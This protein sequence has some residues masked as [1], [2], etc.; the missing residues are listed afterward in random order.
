MAITLAQPLYIL[1]NSVCTWQLWPSMDGLSCAKVRRIPLAW[2]L[3]LKVFFY[4]L[5]PDPQLLQ[6]MSRTKESIHRGSS[7][8]GN[9]NFYFQMEQ[10]ASSLN[11]IQV[12]GNFTLYNKKQWVDTGFTFVCMKVA[13]W[14]SL[15]KKDSTVKGWL[16]SSLPTR[17]KIDCSTK[18]L[19]FQF[20]LIKVSKISRQWVSV[21][22]NLLRGESLS[23]SH[24]GSGQVAFSKWKYSTSAVKNP[25][26]T[27][28]QRNL[29][30]ERGL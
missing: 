28:Q 2:H 1:Y 10:W 26:T 8:S 16:K 13:V 23:N 4:F 3:D 11:D 9:T 30:W 7:D 12:N 14:G 25:L 22:K 18:W 6:A 21:I 19:F 20:T 24:S 27:N 15:V 5:Y 17:Q 29:R